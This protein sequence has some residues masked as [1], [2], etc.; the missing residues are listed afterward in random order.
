VGK[1]FFGFFYELFFVYSFSLFSRSIS[2]SI[3]PN[4]HPH[5]HTPLRVVSLILYK[6]DLS[7]CLK[8]KKL[9]KKKP[10]LL[11]LHPLLDKN[12]GCGG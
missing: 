2:L 4:S 1:N 9:E 8:K 12:E 7:A 6:S 10:E 5:T 3:S 11:S